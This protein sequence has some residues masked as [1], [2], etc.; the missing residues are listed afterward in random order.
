[1]NKRKSRLVVYLSTILAAIAALAA[2][3]VI[4]A[5]RTWNDSH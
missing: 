2:Y 5:A 4:E 3:G 1:M